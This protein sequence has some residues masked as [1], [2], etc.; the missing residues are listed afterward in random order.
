MAFAG[1]ANNLAAAA[2]RRANEFAVAFARLASNVAHIATGS[3][4]DVA[5]LF[6]R[7]VATAAAP[8]ALSV[9]GFAVLRLPDIDILK[10]L[11]FLLIVINI[12]LFT[13]GIVN[14][15]AAVTLI[16]AYGPAAMT[17]GA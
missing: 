17:F 3:A 5:F 4:A 14:G 13:S 1:A 6:Y 12:L 15:S 2:T 11:L 8:S 9:A 16:A 10:H 7:I